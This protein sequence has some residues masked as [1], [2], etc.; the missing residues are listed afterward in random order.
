M[1]ATKEIQDFFPRLMDFVSN[2]VKRISVKKYKYFI[3]WNGIADG[4]LQIGNNYI[5]TNYKIKSID[6]IRKME[7]A[8]RDD[9]FTDLVIVNYIRM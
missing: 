7:K 8:I 9:R 4:K 3:V 5:T 6:Q 1:T 2:C